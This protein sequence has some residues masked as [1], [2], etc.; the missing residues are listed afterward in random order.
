MNKSGRTM[1]LADIDAIMETTIQSSGS[2]AMMADAFR[3]KVDPEMPFGSFTRFHARSE[4]SSG[5]NQGK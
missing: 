3:P 4:V 1:T 5:S 2:F